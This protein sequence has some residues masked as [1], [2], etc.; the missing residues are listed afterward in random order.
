MRQF[1]ETAVP[2]GVRRMDA[3]ADGASVGYVTAA[4]N[5]YKAGHLL[6]E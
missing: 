2:K 1:F 5:L 3:E 6:D 4:E